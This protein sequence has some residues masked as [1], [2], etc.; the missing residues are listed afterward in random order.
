M[1]SQEIQVQILPETC[2]LGTDP[3]EDIL[4]QIHKEVEKRIKDNFEIQQMKKKSL[5]LSIPMDSSGGQEEEVKRAPK[6]ARNAPS[7]MTFDSETTPTARS[8][9]DGSGG[10]FSF[11]DQNEMQYMMNRDPM[12]EFF[13]LTCQSIKL[14]SPHMNAICTIGTV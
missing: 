10:G 13:T 12:Q 8:P 4:K 2:E 6:T 9:N 1:A 3:D 11:K 7:T 5:K 14:N